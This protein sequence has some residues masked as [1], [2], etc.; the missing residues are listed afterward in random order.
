[1]KWISVEEDLPDMYESVI[2]WGRREKEN[3]CRQAY[4][5]RRW[6]G[7]TSGFD[8][9]KDKLW[10]WVTPCDYQVSDVTHWFPMPEERLPK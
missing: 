2:V 4:Q 6:T 1:M 5:A 8:V 7:C 10:Q 3:V 9:E